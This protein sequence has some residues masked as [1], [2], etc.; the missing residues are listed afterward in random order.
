VNGAR[1]RHRGFTHCIEGETPKVTHDTL[2]FG[3]FRLDL[4]DERLWQGQE[5]VSLKAKAFA[6]LRCLVIN[7]GQLMTKDAIFAAV[8]PETVVSESVL[9]VAIR[10][11][12][13]ALGDHARAPRYIETVHGRGYRFIAPVTPDE[14]TP[15]RTPVPAVTPLSSPTPSIRPNVFV[16][17]DS[18]LLAVQAWFDGVQHGA[19]RV[20]FIAGEPG[21]GKTTLVNTIVAHLAERGAAWIGRGQCIQHYGAGE[22]YLPVLEALG[23]LSR[24]PECH[25]L[26][27]I[28][29]HYAP[30]WL[31]HLPTLLSPEEREA[32]ACRTQPVTST[33]MVRELAEAL[34]VLT[35]NHP[36]ILVLEDLHWRDTATLEWLSYVARRHDPARLLVLGTYRP[37][38]VI[39]HPHPLRQLLTELRTHENGAE[40]VLDYLSEAVIEAYLHQRLHAKSFPSDLAHFLHQRTTGN[41]L[42]LTAVTDELVRLHMLVERENS[43]DISGDFIALASVVPTTLQHL[44]QQHV[45]NLA[46][47][48]Q[49]LLE[50]ASVVGPTFSVAAVAAGVPLAEADIETRCTTWTRQGQFLL[51]AGTETWA[52]GTV[53]ACYRFQHALYHEVVYQ[54]V[55]AGRRI[56]LHQQIGARLEGG[57]GNEAPALAAELAMHF[58]QGQDAQRAMVYLLQAA[59]NA[60]RRSAYPEARTHLTNGL[61]LVPQLPDARDRAQYELRLSLALGTVLM[62]TQGWGTPVVE[63]VYLRARELGQQ[64]GDTPHLCLAV[65]GLIAGSVVRAE[66]EKTR[67]LSQELLQLAQGQH[68]SVFH[69]AAHMEL[70]GAAFGSGELTLAHEHFEHSVGLYDLTQHGTHVVR[71]GTDLGVFCRIWDT[72]ALWHLGYPDEARRRSQESLTLARELSHPFSQAIALAYAAMLHQFCRDLQIVDELVD[73]TLTLSTEHGFT[74]YMAWARILQGWVR[75]VQEHSAVGLEQLREGIEA[76]QATGGNVRGPYY[77]AL[78]AEA[79]GYV[80]QID[81]GSLALAEAFAAVQATGECWWEAELHRLTGELVLRQVPPD[82]KRAEIAFHRALT[83]TR[84]QQARALE[85]RAAM[86]LSRLWQQ[87][88]KHTAARELL[89]PIYSWFTEGL[90]TADLQEAQIL[91]QELA[92]GI[93]QVQSAKKSFTFR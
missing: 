33:R 57:Y 37:V 11:L 84:R 2:V 18:E 89:A 73:T 83:I 34:E 78:L 62:A 40:I 72:H 7:A 26:G 66:L 42:F 50:A 92:S 19:R 4:R 45:D 14:G 35:S 39:V 93:E 3:A 63:R 81:Q 75:V 58:T 22:A 53:A 65:W 88:G 23:R 76:L 30:S 36:L 77:R 38:E 54:R 43:W 87:Q 44:I 27:D 24:T 15:V 32:Y 64:L 55:S 52:D 69:I 1:G 90:D 79:Y 8:W 25:H 49:A 10:Q 82:V 80:G 60:M 48:D 67:A 46:S 47:D 86:S 9:T 17:R 12:R 70:A 31:A 85:L 28:L 71:V 74:Y 59:Q 5:T 20:G 13:L 68:D 29:R 61:E 41:P 6:V 21:I 51:A 56:R 16:G 91:L